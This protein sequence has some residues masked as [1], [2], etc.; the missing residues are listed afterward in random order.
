[1]SQPQWTKPGLFPALL[2]DA[3]LWV[4]VVVSLL[5]GVGLWLLLPRGFTAQIIVQPLLLLNLLLLYPVIEEWLFRGVIQ[6]AFLTRPTLV[7]R[8][9]G[10]SGANLL[11]SLLFV[12]LH[13]INHPIYWALATLVPSLALGHMRERYDRL[14][15]P[16]L[17]HIFFN[18]IYLV[19]GI[20]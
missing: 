15:V 19:A 3:H 17:L 9:W 2:R 8:N 11:T 6:G 10:I 20:V 1:M 13:L 12:G 5:V 4:I 7:H 16:I 14:L 18:T